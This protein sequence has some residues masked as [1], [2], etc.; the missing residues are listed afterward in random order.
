LVIFIK[1]YITWLNFLKS[2]I[3]LIEQEIQAL[4]FPRS[5][6]ALY[7]PQR[8]ILESNGKRVRPI[9][10]LMACGLCGGDIKKAM[11]AGVAV[12]LIHNFTLLHDDIMDQ[13]HSRRGKASV[14][15]RWDVAT[16][17]LAGDGMFTQA[18]LQLQH[19][20]ETVNHKLLSKI[21]L[22]GINHVCEGQALD[23]EFENR[24]DVTA[25]EYISMIGGKTAAL[26]KVSLQ[27]GGMV[28]N[29]SEET[30]N[31]LGELG[32]SLGIAFQIQD[33]LLD[34]VAD[35]EK[36]GKKR[37]GDISEGKKTFLMVKALECCTGKEREWLTDKLKNKPLQQDDI[38]RV[39][40]LYHQYDIT[41]LAHSLMNHYYERSS[42]I[43]TGFDD[44][45]Y[46]Q[47][48]KQLITYLRKREF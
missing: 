37:G 12:E 13:A 36:F 40:D 17:I 32:L 1:E 8:Y 19:L 25:D 15:I 10:V 47:D 27:M 3:E 20:P 4:A 30:I 42:K 33:D 44:S 38:N 41:E 14:H 7:S 35:P 18:M 9:L 23:M 21:F 16:A 29:G 28:A 34:V 26:I 45:R 6:E 48:L 43:L 24:L 22:E 46:K 39:I 5:P 2:Y 11:P 31:Q